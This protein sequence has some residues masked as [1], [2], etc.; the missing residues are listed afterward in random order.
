MTPL[1]I[2]A[3]LRQ[4]QAAQWLIDSGA[5]P[6]AIPLYDLGWADRLPALLSTRPDIVNRRMI[7]WGHTPLHEAVNRNDIA[8]AK[9]LL[10]ARPD[11]TIKD[12]KFNAT[13]LHWARHMDRAEIAALIDSVL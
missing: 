4:P 1:E 3:R 9:L 12:T 7:Q 2:T 13:P 6:E 5:T 10:A 11:L 8:L